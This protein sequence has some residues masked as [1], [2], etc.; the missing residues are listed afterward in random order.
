MDL[1]KTLG[2][3]LFRYGLQGNRP[4][5]SVRFSAWMKKEALLT[6]EAN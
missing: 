2:V 4:N 3:E 1:K 5:G 6:V